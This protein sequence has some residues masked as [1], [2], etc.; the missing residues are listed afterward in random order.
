MITS[1]TDLFEHF[2]VD[3]VERLS[4]ALYKNTDCGAWCSIVK[5]GKVQ[6]GTRTETWTANIC[7]SI[8]GPVP[9]TVR[10]AHC[11]AVTRADFPQYVKDFLLLYGQKSEMEVTWD[12]LVTLDSTNPGIVKVTNISDTE[13]FVTFEV[14]APVFKTHT[15]GIT[16]GSIVEGSD[17]G[18]LPST[19]HFPFSADDLDAVIQGIED[20]AD[21][22]WREANTEEVA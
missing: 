13:M 19:L 2:G 3:S 21:R 9:V 20:E 4:R 14:Q 16:I 18:V 17:A 22:L 7:R 6:T 8:A 12:L 10:K 5:P 15:G 1:L 11:K